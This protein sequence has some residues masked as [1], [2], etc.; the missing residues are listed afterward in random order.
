MS[1]G[2]RIK[3]RR[4]EL[5]MSADMLGK[6]IGRSRAT[7][8]KY[9]NGSIENIPYSVMD[10]LAKALATTTDYLTGEI[11]DPEDYLGWLNF[12]GHIIPKEFREDLTDPYDRA[13]AYCEFQQAVYEDSLNEEQDEESL[14]KLNELLSEMFA[15]PDDLVFIPVY[16]N[17]TRSEDLSTK[18]KVL[19]H[20]AFPADMAPKDS[21]GIV[22]QGD[23]MSP[24]VQNKNL[25]VFRRASEVK[26]DKI[27]AFILN[28]KFY[29]KKFK[30][31]VD[32]SRW[33]LSENPDY[34]PI[35]INPEDD[36]KVLG[37]YELKISYA[38]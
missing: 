2:E 14:V 1:V 4:K 11:D 13:K 8:Y 19:N 10:D 29:C 22:F 28:G 25:V 16:S 18:E 17:I 32:G 34:A 24:S 33:L 36:F 9:E 27:G 35:P 7:I 6:E 31:F 15:P 20:L 3:K 5:G 12:S 21:F 23:S 26:S 30:Q 38:H 37:A